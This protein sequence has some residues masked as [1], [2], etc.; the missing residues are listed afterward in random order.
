VSAISILLLEDS[1][2]HAERILAALSEGGPACRVRRARSHEDFAA[3]LAG[4]PV[5]LVLA[6]G[7]PPC[8]DATAVVDLAGAIRP[9]VPVVVIQR[10]PRAEQAVEL[11]RRGAAGYLP[12]DRIEH[13][14]A[15]VERA[16]EDA[17]RGVERRRAE[18]ALRF[19]TE[20]SAVLASS[21]AYE[22]SLVRVAR[23]AV[24]ALADLCWICVAADGSAAGA[25]LCVL[26][27][28]RRRVAVAR[29]LARAS[30]DVSSGASDG[31]RAPI[32]SPA[33]DG[34]HP[35]LCERVDD[36]LL[37][38]RARDE[39]HLRLLRELR[40]TSF[41]AAP[42][43][44]RGRAL[45]AIILGTADPA[46]LYG[47]AHLACVVDLAGRAGA[48][49]GHALLYREALDA[50]RRRDELLARVAHELRTP[51]NA[52]LGW[53]SMLRTRRL[54]EAARA[55]AL[56]TIERNAR[57]EARLIEGLLD[58]S[59]MM[60]GTLRL[61]VIEVELCPAIAAVVESVRPTAEARAITLS[62]TLDETA[63]SVAGDPA[64]LRQVL[65]E[66]C[67]NAIRATPRG[68]RVGVRLARNG[69]TEAEIAVSDDGRGIRAD[70]LPHLFDGFPRAAAAGHGSLG[71][72]LSIARHL[73]EAHGGAIA[74]ESAGE[75]RGATFTV[76]LP[77]LP[78]EWAERPLRAHLESGAR[79]PAS[80]VGV[81]RD[82]A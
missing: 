71:V 51:L 28:D 23:L 18:E 50:A 29:A 13:L 82:P 38:A 35:E 16:I 15:A 73:V 14:G 44:A 57:T 59:R 79:V 80:G 78:A 49:V 68:G 10:S 69:S 66:L 1:D 55:R 21:L 48:A 81:I 62:A 41:V 34:G 30:D 37:E 45:G 32:P 8:V 2:T 72:G 74:A 19:L 20:A 5:D 52:M 54:D 25:P 31:S 65:H 64:R 63:G 17:A 36:A 24:P 67:V 12:G 26:E 33:L 43:A 56:E 11:L 7:A 53:A 70:L 47:P 60:S 46:R 6:G 27:G 22:E 42:I 75:G 40:L 76:R 77:L 4:G 58:L 9:D 39:R 61:E 3:V